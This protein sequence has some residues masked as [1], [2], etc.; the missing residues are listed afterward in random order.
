MV[1]VPVVTITVPPVICAFVDMVPLKD[2]KVIVLCAACM[3]A[4]FS[5]VRDCSPLK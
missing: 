2:T 1:P 3:A 5:K 4:L